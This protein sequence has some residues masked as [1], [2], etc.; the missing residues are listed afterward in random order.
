LKLQAIDDSNRGAH[1]FLTPDDR[2]FFLHEFTARKGYNY[3]P[4]NQ[5]IFNFKKS[6]AQQH[7]PHFAY[8]LR[9]IQEAILMY[10][11]IF[12]QVSHLYDNCTFTPVPPSKVKGHPEYD[13]RMW[14]VVEGVCSGFNADARELIIQTSSYDSAHN[15]GQS[16]RRIKPEELVEL[17]QVDTVA[18]KSTVLLFDDVLSAGCH[19]RAAKTAILET[20]PGVDVIGLFLAR[21]VVPDPIIDFDLP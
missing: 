3:S 1:Y 15:V 16:G 5:F 19:F 12:S 10:R 18:P 7:E 14:Q 2:C 9:A 20:H 17:Y 6:P 21:R 4:G 13:D 11:A 8:K